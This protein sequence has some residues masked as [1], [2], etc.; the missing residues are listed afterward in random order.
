MEIVRL[1]KRPAVSAA[2]FFVS[3]ALLYIP[4]TP[5]FPLQCVQRA[6]KNPCGKPHYCCTRAGRQDLFKMLVANVQASKKESFAQCH[7]LSVTRSKAAAGRQK[8][9]VA[10]REKASLTRRLCLQSPRRNRRAMRLLF[11]AGPA[12]KTRRRGVPETPA[13]RGLKRWSNR[14]QNAPRAGK[15]GEATPFSYPFPDNRLAGI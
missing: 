5:C 4:H 8:D 1:T 6:T 7:G 3:A 13:G 9:C 11:P 12:P 2:G 10:K 15:K 14:A